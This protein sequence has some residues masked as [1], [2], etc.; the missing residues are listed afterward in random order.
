MFILGLPDPDPL[1]LVRGMDPDHEAGGGGGGQGAGSPPTLLPRQRSFHPLPA[2]ECHRSS[3]LIKKKSM[4]RIHRIH[5]FFFGPPGSGSIVRGMDPRIRIL[6][7]RSWIWNTGRNFKKRF[8][9]M[10][11]FFIFFFSL[12]EQTYNIYVY[13]SSRTILLSS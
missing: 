8:G 11:P 6:T 5:M 10:L 4:F 3:G 13:Y 9:G 7:K 1:L 2:T 12:F